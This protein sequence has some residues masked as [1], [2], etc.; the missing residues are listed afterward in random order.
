MGLASLRGRRAG[1]GPEIAREVGPTAGLPTLDGRAWPLDGGDSGGSRSGS[2]TKRSPSHSDQ[3]TK[4]DAA[5]RQ[6]R[7]RVLAGA[8]LLSEKHFVRLEV[9]YDLKLRTGQDRRKCQPEP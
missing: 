8:A 4:S 1:N 3:D 7:F 2:L 5:R 6:P 9:V